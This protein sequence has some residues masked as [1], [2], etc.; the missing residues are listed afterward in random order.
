MCKVE[1]AMIAI[2][3]YDILKRTKDGAYVWLEAAVDLEEA[4]RR[5]WELSRRECEIIS[6]SANGRRKL[7]P[8]LMHRPK[9]IPRWL[10]DVGRAG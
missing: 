1:A 6:F 8:S 5:M 3:Q 10:I 4:K 9:L 7:S 2:A